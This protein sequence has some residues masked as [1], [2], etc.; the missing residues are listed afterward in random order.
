MVV[1]RSS[2]PTK[3]PVLR[4]SAVGAGFFVA[5]SIHIVLTAFGLGVAFLGFD[6][7]DGRVT[8]GGLLIWSGFAWLVGSFIG[9]YVTAWLGET[10]RYLEGLLHG[11]VLWGTLTLML[12]FLPPSTMG[13]GVVGS[14]AL[15]EPDVISSVAWFIAI[16]GLLSLGTAIG[17]TVMGSRAMDQVEAQAAETQRAA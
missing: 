11:L 5:L 14:E 3:V 15:L 6:A 17:G 13:I 1:A 8:A 12:L 2:R 10:L 7:P 16:G 4:W 9:G